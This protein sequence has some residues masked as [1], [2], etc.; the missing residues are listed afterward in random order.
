MY[1]SI[2]MPFLSSIYLLFV[3][4]NIYLMRKLLIKD[5][6]RIESYGDIVLTVLIILLSPVGTYIINKALS[7][8]L[9]ADEI[10]KAKEKSKKIINKIFFIK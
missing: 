8:F 4:Y 10:I 7:D 5:K 1:I 2:K 9:T 3:I 6:N